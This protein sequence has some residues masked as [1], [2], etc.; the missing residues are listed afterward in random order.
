MWHLEGLGHSLIEGLAGLL[1]GAWVFRIGEWLGLAAWHLMPARRTTILRNLRIAFGDR[2]SPEDLRALAMASIRRSGANLISAAYTA[3]LPKARLQQVMEVDNRELLEQAIAEGRGVVLLLSHMGN[4]ELLSRLIHLLPDG[5]RTGA[6]YRP[7]NNELLDQRILK[8]READGTRMFSK[9]DP[10]HQV[11]GFLRDGGVVGI[12]ADQ[13]VGVQGEVVSFFGRHTRSSP[14]PSLL[15]RRTKSRVL[16]LSM[17]CTGPERWRATLMPV[18]E[19]YTTRHCTE[20]LEQA[21]AASPVD[22]FWL[23]ERWRPLLRRKRG[24]RQWLGDMETRSTKPHRALL[25]PGRD[26]TG[27]SLTDDWIHPDVDYEVV[28]DTPPAGCPPPA[29]CHPR[30]TDERQDRLEQLLAAIDDGQPL[31]LDVVI[32]HSPPPSLQ[33]ACIRRG[34]P[35]IDLSQVHQA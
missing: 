26:A 17:T 6:F 3:R 18:E 2:K 27:W 33:Q 10:F 13:R 32:A 25:W 15:A 31:P 7:L 30:P 22:V 23:Q 20:A 1:P 29:A 34:I 35:M 14:L 5:T 4:W 16:A 21:M 9:R 28:G 8:R 24:F 11:C 12:L 19:P